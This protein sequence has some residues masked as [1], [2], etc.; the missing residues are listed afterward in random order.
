MAELRK[1]RRGEIGRQHVTE[2]YAAASVY[3]WSHLSN[4]DQ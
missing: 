3:V 2:H 1:D 4:P